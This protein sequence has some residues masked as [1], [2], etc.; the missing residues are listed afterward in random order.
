MAMLLRVALLLPQVRADFHYLQGA[1]YGS[2]GFNA[3]QFGRWSLVEDNIGTALHDSALREERLV[4][5]AELLAQGFRAVPAAR[6]TWSYEQPGPGWVIGFT[7]W[8][9]KDYR[10]VWPLLVQAAADS[11]A[12]IGLYAIAVRLWGRAAALAAAL[13]YAL[14]APQAQL[15]A[16][17]LYNV[18]SGPLLIGLIG[19]TAWAPAL[20]KH[21]LV[22][23]A[24]SG[25]LVGIGTLFAPTFLP[26]LVVPAVIESWRR[27]F[28][29]ILPWLAAAAAALLLCLL[30]WA[31]RNY[32]H[33]GELR[34]IASAMW[35]NLYYGLVEQDDSPFG[36][37]SQRAW[38]NSEENV[39]A[40]LR[41][42]RG[43][44]T[45][46]TRESEAAFR[47]LVLEALRDEPIYFSKLVASRLLAAVSMADPTAD[48]TWRVDTARDCYL[49]IA[50]RSVSMPAAGVCDR[51]Y[52]RLNPWP[53]PTAWLIGHLVTLNRPFRIR[54]DGIW[55]YG[56]RFATFA[57]IGLPLLALVGLAFGARRSP[58]LATGF[59]LAVLIWCGVY[60]INHLEGRYVAGAQA[61]L[62][63]AAWAGL[64][65]VCLLVL[66]V[67]RRFTSTVLPTRSRSSL[68]V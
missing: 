9:T 16:F 6:G 26:L 51:E 18:W 4:D 21:Q 65:R 28:R 12:V 50:G 5:P 57:V 60:A 10:F 41:E 43:L 40:W 37:N 27:G 54:V 7:W 33:H 61:L 55:V 22:H 3:A 49:A 31:F 66:G 64:T 29:Q 46:Y 36:P 38:P 23:G 15:A 34:P 24:L 19:L 14:F 2:W 68:A 56:P 13:G 58:V 52:A 67:T 32:R 8:I 47:P 1:L 44:K 20:R 45:W 35:W 11:L 53:A 63:A 59:A 42:T 30:P 39:F 48:V 25:F 17:P 62:T